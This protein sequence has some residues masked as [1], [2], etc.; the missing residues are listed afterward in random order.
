L[1]FQDSTKE[2]FMKTVMIHGS[3]GEVMAPF[4]SA[5][6]FIRGKRIGLII[7]DVGNDQDVP[8]VVRQALIGLSV[9]A[10]FTKK[11][12]VDQCGKRFSD[13]PEDCLLGYV[14]EVIE[15]LEA[16]KKWE[17]IGPLK[18]VAGDALD[19]YVFETGTFR[20]LEP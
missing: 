4:G 19:M 13:L 5:G 11:Q 12:I 20:V 15:V 17:A 2:F 3:N 18:K 14:S 9:D 16:A 10:M 8:L 6:T 7:I 1:I